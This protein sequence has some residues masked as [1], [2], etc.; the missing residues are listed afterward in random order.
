MT[1][2]AAFQQAILA[3]LPEEYRRT[4]PRPLSGE[5]IEPDP[6]AYKDDMAHAA[7]L[8]QE[9]ADTATLAYLGQFLHGVARCAG[10]KS[11]RRRQITCR[12]GW[13]RANR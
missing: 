2:L 3:Q 9:N 11:W 13:R 8:L 6:V 5:P 12:R 10:T 4:G 7:E 1:S